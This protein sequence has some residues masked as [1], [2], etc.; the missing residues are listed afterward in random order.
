MSVS[1]TQD[2][3]NPLTID[4]LTA[5]TTTTKQYDVSSVGLVTALSPLVFPQIRVS[6]ASCGVGNTSALDVA[7]KGI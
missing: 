3:A 5:A 6:V 7:L 2:F 1:T 4:T